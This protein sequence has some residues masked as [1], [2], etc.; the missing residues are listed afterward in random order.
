[1]REPTAALPS[2]GRLTLLD[3]LARIFST[4]PAITRLISLEPPTAL[5]PL[6]LASCRTKPMLLVRLVPP[7]Q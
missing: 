7:Y 1:M 6:N 5:H 3:A 2:P 4:R